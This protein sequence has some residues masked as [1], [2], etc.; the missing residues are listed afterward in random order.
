M[1]LREKRSFMFRTRPLF[2][3]IVAI[4]GGVVNGHGAPETDDVVHEKPWDA[5]FGVGGIELGVFGEI[6]LQYNADDCSADAE[7]FKRPGIGEALKGFRLPNGSRIE[8]STYP[9]TSSK[10]DLS[11]RFVKV[12]G[13][14][15]GLQLDH[16]WQGRG[17]QPLLNRDLDA[18][19]CS[20]MTE[21]ASNRSKR[22]K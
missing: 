19:A 18:I 3:A 17:V 2:A 21:L 10:T 7:V 22:P 16:F 13:Y 20:P 15:C 8:C 5:V 12:L 11:N 9:E 14:K 6:P 4:L 1:S